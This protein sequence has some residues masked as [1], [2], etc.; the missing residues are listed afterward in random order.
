L[1]KK[2]SVTPRFAV[3]SMKNAELKEAHVAEKSDL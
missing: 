2:I 3:D 1:I